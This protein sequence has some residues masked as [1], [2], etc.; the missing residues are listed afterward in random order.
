MK[1]KYTVS[2]RSSKSTTFVLVW[3]AN[4]LE[5]IGR[6]RVVV[7]VRKL[8]CRVVRVC[9]GSKEENNSRLSVEPPPLPSPRRP[10][11]HT[12]L[13]DRLS[14]SLKNLSRL[15]WASVTACFNYNYETTL[16]SIL[17][18]FY[19]FTIISVIIIIVVIIIFIVTVVTI[20][21]VITIKIRS[22]HLS[23]STKTN[24][25]FVLFCPPMV[26]RSR[27]ACNHVD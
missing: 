22:Y 19:T 12:Y 23:L 13:S 10:L 14:Q 24:S 16:F 20:F 3:R 5:S 15:C 26:Y 11:F 18:R 9:E 1:K 6:A 8:L 2:S 7:R 21:M 27:N 25:V 17:F 4:K